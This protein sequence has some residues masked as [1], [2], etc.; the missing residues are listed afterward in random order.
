MIFLWG[1][2]KNCL[3]ERNFS[4]KEEAK[5][6]ITEKCQKIKRGVLADVWR[7]FYNRQ[8]YWLA[9]NVQHFEHLI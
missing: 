2:L 4:N 8:G 1:Y 9:A 6:I 5:I 3:H 7:E